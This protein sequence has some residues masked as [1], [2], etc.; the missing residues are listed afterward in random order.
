[1]G[2]PS[3]T[4]AHPGVQYLKEKP[5]PEDIGSRYGDDADEKKEED[6]GQHTGSG[7]ED[8]IS[9]ENTGNSPGGSDHRDLGIGAGDDLDQACPQSGKEVEKCEPEA[10]EKVF[11]VIPEYPEKKHIPQ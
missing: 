5:E 10:S 7:I 9:A 2:K 6:E 1:M 8:E 11:H 3:D 4:A